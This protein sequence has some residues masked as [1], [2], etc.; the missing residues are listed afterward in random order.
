MSAI[1]IRSAIAT[2]LARLI[3]IDHACKTDYVWQLDRRSELTQ[4]EIAF[5][6]VR[7]PRSVIAA[8]PRAINRLPDEWHRTMMLAALNGSEPIGYIRCTDQ[9]ERG[10]LSITDLVV[11]QNFRRQTIASQ[12]IDAAFA[13]GAQRKAHR[14][15]IEM[16]SKHHPAIKLAQKLGFEFCGYSDQYYETRDIAIF[17]GINL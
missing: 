17:F 13:W 4:V 8:Y 9:F 1:Q 5:R 6:E 7:L 15:V 14:A 16:T 3:E 12:L 2:D 10:L 11:A